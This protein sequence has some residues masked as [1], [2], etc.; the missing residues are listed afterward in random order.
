MPP[1]THDALPIMTNALPLLFKTLVPS[2][3]LVPSVSVPPWTNWTPQVSSPAGHRALA[4]PICD[5]ALS[6][7]ATS[8]DSCAI[9]GCNLWARHP[10]LRANC[11]ATHLYRPATPAPGSRIVYPTRRAAQSWTLYHVWL[12]PLKPPHIAG[13]E[14]CLSA[15]KPTIVARWNGP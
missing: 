12:D 11:Q 5:H 13:P 15:H 4:V 2:Q 3:A 14:P 6:H 1:V 9:T 7:H 10:S 8:H